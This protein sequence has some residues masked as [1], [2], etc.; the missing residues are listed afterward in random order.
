MNS[1]RRKR[2]IIAFMKVF[3]SISAA[4]FALICALLTPVSA[5]AAHAEQT[6]AGQPQELYA[7]A[8]ERN[9]YLYSS[10]DEKSGLFILPY[11]Y[12]VK[13]LSLGEPFC[14]VEYQ[15]DVPPYKKVTGYCKKQSLTFVDFVPTRP[16]LRRE[17]TVTYTLPEKPA[18][19]PSDAFTSV[20]V[21]YLFY[22]TYTV[23][24]AEYFYVYGNGE[25]GYLPATEEIVYD[26]NTDYLAAVSAP[27]EEPEPPSEE[28]NEG[29]SGLQIFFICALC[30]SAVA[31]ALFVLHGKKSPASSAQEEHS[32]F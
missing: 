18:F 15:D 17:I 23:G 25:F 9:I 8:A 11:T 29:L 30:V 24:S 27:T 14:R 20:S 13:V 31:V 16:F 1:F 6:D 3:L 21:S 7:V 26:L 2:S 32:D 10:A 19:S 5:L 22:G 28:K 4:L 12:Y